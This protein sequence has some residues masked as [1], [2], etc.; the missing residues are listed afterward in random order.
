M[1]LFRAQI[2]EGYG[3]DKMKTKSN[4]FVLAGFA[5]LIFACGTKDTNRADSDRSKLNL[6]AK[7]QNVRSTVYKAKEN[8]GNIE[9]TEFV[10]DK[11]IVFDKK[12]IISEEYGFSADGKLNFKAWKDKAQYL[13]KG[14][15][16]AAN[17]SLNGNYVYDNDANGNRISN[18]FYTPDRTLV[19]KSIRSYDPLGNLTE[20]TSFGSEGDVSSKDIYAYNADHKLIECK[21]LDSKG[22]QNSRISYEY[23]AESSS[24]NP[25]GNYSSSVEYDGADNPLREREF[26]YNEDGTT[27]TELVNNYT[28]EATYSYER[29]YDDNRNWISEVLKR[30]GV[31]TQITERQINISIP[32]AYTKI[33]DIASPDKRIPEIFATSIRAGYPAENVLDGNPA[34]VWMPS[35]SGSGSGEYL[36]FTF[37]DARDIGNIVIVPG[38]AKD[39]ESWT[40][41]NRTNFVWVEYSGSTNIDTYKFNVERKAHIIP[42]NRKDIESVKITLDGAEPGSKFDDSCISEVKF[43]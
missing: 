7:V 28:I 16:L 23:D 27:L 2:N 29:K 43:Y 37:P 36:S 39:D 22:S 13:E 20:L 21:S 6:S 42:L 40:A 14:I 33:Q 5:L 19:F 9:K 10:S 15:S 12:G 38:F 31:V 8:F 35:Y 25:K 34:T 4:L 41:Y 3:E 24:S 26:T 17:G 1:I 30:N 11:I 32:A 18:S